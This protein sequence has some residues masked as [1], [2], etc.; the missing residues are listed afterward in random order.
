VS[1]IYQVD[2]IAALKALT[3]LNDCALVLGYYAPGDGGG[4]LF[5]YDPNNTSNDDGGIVIAPTNGQG[6]WIRQLAASGTINVQEFGARGD[7]KM[8][9]DPANPNE[10]PNDTKAFAAASQAV[11]N[12]GGG[13]LVIPPGTYIVGQHDFA[14]AFGKGYA[15]NNNPIITINDCPRPVVIE[16][17]GAVL[18]LNDN[19]RWGLFDP[20]TG[21]PAS[22]VAPHDLRD[23]EAGPGAVIQVLRNAAMSISGLEIDGNIQNLI[24]G[25]EIE[26]QQISA[27]GIQSIDNKQLLI[28]DVYTHH[29]G[30]DGV[31]ITSEMFLKEDD[32]AYPNVLENVVSEYNG[33]QGLSWD[34]GT[35]LTAIG[36]RFSQT[37]Q[38]IHNTTKVKIGVPPGAGIDIETEN[39]DCHHGVFISCEFSHNAGPGMQAITGS[40]WKVSNLSFYN[41]IFRYNHNAGLNLLGDTSDL[42]FHSCKFVG[43]SVSGV[44][45]QS[46]VSNATFNDCTFIGTGAPSLGSVGK[47]FRFQNC[48]IAGSVA[49]LWHAPRQKP[50]GDPDESNLPDV[51]T[52][53]EGCLFTHDLN[54]SPSGILYPGPSQ[55]GG[56]ASCQDFSNTQNVVFERCDFDAGLLTLP[57]SLFGAPST[58]P[59]PDSLDDYTFYSN[60]TF[61]QTQPGTP[62]T[63]G[64]FL[65]MNRFEIADSVSANEL[66]SQNFSLT[67]GPLYLNGQRLRS[68]PNQTLDSI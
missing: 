6:R 52:R 48:V 19:L 15:Y 28:K 44:L 38:A 42:S 54:Y 9:K 43:N 47:Y 7:G 18:K 59:D 16:G 23:Y 14:G 53:F 41:C 60:C 58:R 49:G 27:Y 20:V 62:L 33:R 25:L 10:P 57:N 24:L 36:C 45:S 40:P 63:A 29:H 50:A 12:I 35:Q 68:K 46:T 5:R 26:K 64:F 61:K 32:P 37:G 56:L 11:A 2:S 34:G 66:F 4:G 22:P 30:L 55:G 3:T 31:Y 65:G 13:K 39:N 17:F 1:D 51:A 21:Q 67:S 8:M